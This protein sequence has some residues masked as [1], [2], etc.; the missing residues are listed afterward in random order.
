ASRRRGGR[1]RETPRPRL[2]ARRQTGWVSPARRNRRAVSR[3]RR[4]SACALHDERGV[5]PAKGEVVA[6]HVLDLERAPL[7]GDVI[8]LTAARIDVLEVQCRREPARVHHLDA[9]PGL[10]RSA[11]PERVAEE[12]LLA[13]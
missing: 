9:E 2:C 8:E 5:D 12:T 6:H 7:A 10:D 13:R 1:S 4:A 11:C 3:W